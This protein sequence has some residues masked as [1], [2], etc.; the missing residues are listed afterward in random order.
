MR[1][2]VDDDDD[3]AYAPIK[4]LTSAHCL[5]RNRL[6]DR[7]SKGAVTLD[8]PESE[9]GTFD[10]PGLVI[11]RDSNLPEGNGSMEST[12]ND[13]KS[14]LDKK[15]KKKF[16]KLFRRGSKKGSLKDDITKVS[17][18][19]DSTGGIEQA[20]TDATRRKS[21]FIPNSILRKSA[22][23]DPQANDTGGK[24][25]QIIDVPSTAMLF[26]NM[27]WFLSNLD[28]LCGKV[29]DALLKSFSQKLTEWALQPWNDNKD[30]ALSDAT[31]DMRNGLNVINLL[32]RS[33]TKENGKKWAPVINPVNSTEYLMSII[34]EESYILPSAHFPLLLTFGS[35]T[36]LGSYNTTNSKLKHGQETETF[37][38]T[39]VKI[40]VVRGKAG[41]EKNNE[42]KEGFAYI[43]HANVGGSVKETGKS[44]LDPYYD[45]STHRWHDDNNLEFETSSSSGYPGAIT[46]RLSSVSLHN[47]GKENITLNDEN[48]ITYYSSEVGFSFIELGKMWT[49]GYPNKSSFQVD[50]FD[51]DSQPEFDQ[52]G[53]LSKD[54]K[55]VS[56]VRKKL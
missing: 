18:S 34:P 29:E 25:Q 19:C 11:S 20:K 43:V 13:K 39:I 24:E 1:K 12:D 21:N 54:L 35:C 45:S 44:T 37:Y 6:L 15:K 7:D 17:E 16:G 53:L 4:M 28:Q 27:G 49:K 42:Q 52:Q 46:L 3:S 38:R 8:I 14:G 23:Q 5:L 32:G 40:N 55:V 51:Y 2:K 47:S 33:R 26:E 22:D 31:A 9:R 56:E 41:S 50:V 10:Q 30:R 48:G 36:R